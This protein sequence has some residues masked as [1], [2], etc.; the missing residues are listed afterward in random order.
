M[1][2]LATAATYDFCL[3]SLGADMDEGTVL[4]WRVGP[5]DHVA[6]G[7]I[8]LVVDTE[9]SAID[10]ESW[11]EGT[12]LELLVPEGET[13]RVGTA[14]ARMGSRSETPPAPAPPPDAP[15]P[16]PGA[17]PAAAAPVTS[18]AAP[19]PVRSPLIR[20]LADQHGVDLATVRGSGPGGRV[21]RHDVERA[22]VV[23]RPGRAST[24]LPA[25]PRARALATA[26]NIDLRTL[27]GTGPA[28][29]VLARDVPD[30]PSR[31][32]AGPPEPRADGARAAERRD[33]MR[34]VIAR[35]MT[36]SKQEIPHY[37][38]MDRID[39]GPASTWLAETNDDR[40]VKDRI[41]MAALLVKATALAARRHPELNGFWRDGG[42][43]PAHHVDVGLIVSLRG[44]GIVAPVIHDADE[45]SLAQVMA[46]MRELV[47]LARAGRLPSSAVT[48][49]SI[50][51]TN[52]GE[53]GAESVHG[54]IY[55]PQV[56]IIGFGRVSEQP[57]VLDGAVVAR[58]SV[59]VTL[60]GDH[61]AT[62]GATGSRFLRTVAA[63]LA[64][65]ATLT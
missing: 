46:D 6:K 48:P 49:P 24:R 34:A 63:L 36:R 26:R 51:V 42:Y 57:L 14:L 10:V 43:E 55:P 16:T 2:D 29:A 21:T 23:V 39:L 4:E 44:G 35:L 13:V 52:L 7:D 1:T 12:V 60:A 54:V 5:G 18:S 8:L 31:P 3:P 9:K 37:Y 17:A 65:P 58:P 15:V 20:H 22:A 27:A 30:Q 28:G 32:D 61:R 38:L 56:A 62:D 40:P 25:S 50:T 59:V 47:S 41:V 64:E 53:Q 33:A 45:R 19:P 11:H